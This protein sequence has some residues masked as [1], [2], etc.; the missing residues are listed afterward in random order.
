MP[1]P[2]PPVGGVSVIQPTSV[3]AFHLHPLV[4]VTAMLPDAG[5][6]P[7]ACA[8]GATT[9]VHAAGSRLGPTTDEVPLQPAA[10]TAAA[11]TRVDRTAVP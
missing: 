6:L 5:K 4:A 3:V 1:F 9:N 7:T 2:I 10:T 11:K 8:A